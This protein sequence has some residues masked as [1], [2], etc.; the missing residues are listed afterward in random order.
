MVNRFVLLIITLLAIHITGHT[1]DYPGY[2][3]YTGPS[4]DCNKSYERAAILICSLAD[5]SALDQTPNKKIKDWRSKGDRIEVTPHDKWVISVR[6]KC[7]TPDCLRTAYL[8]RIAELDKYNATPPVSI[9]QESKIKIVGKNTTEV[10]PTILGNQSTVATT[11]IDT[12]SRAQQAVAAV[13]QKEASLR[14]RLGQWIH[15]SIATVATLVKSVIVAVT[16]VVLIVILFSF[17]SFVN[18]IDIPKS[19]STNRSRSSLSSSNS[20]GHNSKST[21]LKA[22]P[23]DSRSQKNRERQYIYDVTQ[24]GRQIYVRDK[25]KTLLK[26]LDGEIIHWDSD[27]VEYKTGP[28]TAWVWSF[29]DKTNIRKIL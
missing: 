13:D 22:A 16:L 25:H 8:E 19:S 28:R 17:L 27:K 12:G 26:R 24:H 2:P 7:P 21:I 10:T 18:S 6:N 14:E 3:G 29:K 9:S 11:I 1:D 5:L 15:K 23:T 20:T 4:F